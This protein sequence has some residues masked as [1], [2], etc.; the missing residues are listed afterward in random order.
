MRLIIDGVSI[1]IYNYYGTSVAH[2]V[3]VRDG[4]KYWRPVLQDASTAMG[5]PRTAIPALC[6]PKVMSY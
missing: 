2:I 5:T 4:C 3:Y 6:A 1:S